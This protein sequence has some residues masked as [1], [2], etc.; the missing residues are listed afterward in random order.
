MASK[1]NLKHEVKQIVYDIMDEC[2][3]AIITDAKSKGKAEKLMD[4]VVEFYEMI[5]PK[6]SATKSKAD[7]RPLREE[8]ETALNAMSAKLNEIQ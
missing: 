3:Y 5:I 4:E 7:F 6:I 8:I 2:D 1:K